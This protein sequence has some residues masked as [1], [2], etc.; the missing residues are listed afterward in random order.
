MPNLPSTDAPKPRIMI[1]T[2][3]TGGGHNARA[4]AF[5]AW[6]E[7]RFPN[8]VEV[9]IAYPLERGNRIGKVGVESYNLIQKYA[10]FL[11]NPYW[12]LVE[13]IGLL[14]KRGPCFG[15]RRYEQELKAFQPHLILSVH[16]FL[17]RGY[18]Q[19]A[20]QVLG[21]HVPC[22]TYCGEFSG[23][24]GY[25]AN[26]VEPTC[27]RF[28]S[29]TRTAEDYAI[30]LGMPP[31]KCYL[32]HH[33]LPPEAVQ[34]R[35]LNRENFMREQLGL[36]PGRF[37]VFL[38]SAGMGANHHLRFLKVIAG[39]HPEVQA[40]VVCGK[41]NRTLDEVRQ[42]AADHPQMKVHVEGYCRRMH[43]LMQIADCVVTRGATT[44]SEARFF[45]VP[46]IFSAIGGIMPQERLTFKY[47]FRAG[48]AARINDS[49]DFNYTLSLWKTRGREYQLAKD[50]MSQLNRPE[51]T[52]TFIG[53]MVE[54]ARQ[55]ALRAKPS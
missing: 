45:G 46:I 8:Q 1:L 51:D 31:E 16:D 37:T 14:Q 35:I 38:P 22:V 3:S 41:N 49:E 28:Y 23:G 21:N 6:C 44:C 29:R 19:K 11:H 27:D 47:F 50:R 4:N 48:A 43:E 9:C 5:K 25:S 34:P 26:W 7:E 17:N 30:K 12:C 55:T 54:L 36:D 18:F 33:F 24:F 42:W 15:W 52:S 13:A 53:D 2:A 40:V 10:P 20:R 39:K 32:V